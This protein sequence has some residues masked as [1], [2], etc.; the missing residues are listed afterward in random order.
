MTAA[1]AAALE[2]HPGVDFVEQD[3]VVRADET[4][5]AGAWGIDRIDQLGLPLDG[6]YTYSATGS[7]VRAYIIDT[8]IRR[9]HTQFGGRVVPAFTSISDGYGA[10]GCNGHGTHV[11]GTLGGATVGVAKSVMLYSVRVLDCNGA[12]TISS[13]VAG[14]DWVTSNRILPAVA[15]MSLSAELSPALNTAIENSISAGVVYVVAAGNSASDACGYSPASTANAITVGATTGAD[16]LASYSNTGGCVDIYAPGSTIHSAWNTDDNAMIGLS[17]TSMSSPHVAGAIALYLQSDPSANPQQAWQAIQSAATVNA[18]TG[19][20]ASSINRL[21]RVNGPDAGVVLPPPAAQPAPTP[22]N[23]PPS[24]AFTVSCPSQK[25]NCSFDASSS[26]DDSGIAQFSW[27]FGD[28][29]SSISAA[30]PVAS[31]SYR[32][33]GNYTVTLTVADEAG[34]TSTAQRTVTVKSVSRN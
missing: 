1:A 7:G 5:Y 14:V 4:S 19:L 11:A 3:R 2:Q 12:G 20:N 26:R 13:V 30:N 17:G 31:H 9:T 23:S 10:D 34:L 29:T 15:N 6:Q 33:K 18:V 25:N 32:A 27:S 22:G 21:L 24:A 28:G 8:G 16:A